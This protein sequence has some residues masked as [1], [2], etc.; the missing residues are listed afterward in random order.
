[1]NT[2][3]PI[4]ISDAVNSIITNLKTIY[5]SNCAD[6]RR[7][8]G[9]ALFRLE[10]HIDDLDIISWLEQQGMPEKIYYS[11]RSHTLEI[12]GIGSADIISGHSGVDYKVLQ[13]ELKRKLSACGDGVRYYGGISFD[14]SRKCDN[15]WEEFGSYRFVL[16]LVEIFKQNNE[17]IYAVNILLDAGKS[18]EGQLRFV[19]S[20]LRNSLVSRQSDYNKDAVSV[21][22]TNIP[23]H[24]EWLAR[25]EKVLAEIDSSE[26][27]KIVLARRAVFSLS[28]HPDPIKVLSILKRTNPHC[29]HFC[30][31]LSAILIKFLQSHFL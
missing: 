8:E 28:G 9:N 7:R 26:V 2:N 29:F 10:Q 17:T 12:A 31:Q 3:T 30:F 27:E 18:A 15:V 13:K 4:P 16:P 21:S 22:R 11:N 25:A 1:M 14:T 6:S 23:E 24:A 20:A 19:E 5:N